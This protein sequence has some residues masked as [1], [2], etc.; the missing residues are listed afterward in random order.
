MVVCLPVVSA[1]VTLINKVLFFGMN[2]ENSVFAHGP[3]AGI[4][5]TLFWKIV[6]PPNKSAITESLPVVKSAKFTAPA[7]LTVIILSR[8][9]VLLIRITGLALVLAAIRPLKEYHP[10]PVDNWLSPD[11]LNRLASAITDSRFRSSRKRRQWE[12]RRIRGWRPNRCCKL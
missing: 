9:P 1:S 2:K 6:T 10:I 3:G 8:W 7:K 12:L 11:R 5:W 4:V